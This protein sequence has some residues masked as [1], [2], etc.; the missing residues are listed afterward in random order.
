M[1]LINPA[2]GGYA[3]TPN[4]DAD[5]PNG[6]TTCL[7]V[8]GEGSLTVIMRDGMTTTFIGAS[9]WMPIQVERVKETGTDATDIVACYG[10]P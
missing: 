6:P 9:G 3:V 1:D 5:L 10:S 8:G 4:D 7:W 2:S